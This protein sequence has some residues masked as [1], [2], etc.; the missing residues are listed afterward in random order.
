MTEEGNRL[1]HVTVTCVVTL[2]ILCLEKEQM[3]VMVKEV[4]DQLVLLLVEY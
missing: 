1:L 4:V 2:L 3:A